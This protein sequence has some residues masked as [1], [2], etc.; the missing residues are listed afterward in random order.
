M[1]VRDTLA[2][3]RVSVFAHGDGPPDKAR[4]LAL[5]GRMLASAAGQS[6][7]LVERRLTER[8]AVQSTA[9]GLGVAIP[10]AS[11]PSLDR[12]IAALVI[13]PSG[14]SFEAIDGEPTRLILGVLGPNR[15]ADHLR[16]LAR[17]SKLLRA[18]PIRRALLDA[19]DAASAL[20]LIDA[21]EEGTWA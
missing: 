11:L 6:A 7:E 10:H 17:V 4:V 19:P 1:R 2:E 14:V 16:F 20:S 15:A 13:H 9:I 3:D 5:L 18:A 12:Q 21:V 8:E